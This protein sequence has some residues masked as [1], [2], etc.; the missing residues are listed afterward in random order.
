M[1]IAILLGV[2]VIAAFGIAW[3]VAGNDDAEYKRKLKEWC[4][5]ICIGLAILFFF[6]FI[7][8]FI[9]PWIFV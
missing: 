9:A 4:F 5:N 7:L 2:L 3:S 1:N 6:S 8:R